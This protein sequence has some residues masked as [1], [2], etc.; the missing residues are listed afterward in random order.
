MNDNGVSLWPTLTQARAIAEEMG[1]HMERIPDTNR[2]RLSTP[3]GLRFTCTL[4]PD[5]EQWRNALAF[6][7]RHLPGTK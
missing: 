4:F 5:M 2:A 7:V 6:G 3:D 1:L